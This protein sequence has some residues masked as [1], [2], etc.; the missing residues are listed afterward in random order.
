MAAEN[1]PQSETTT[2]HSLTAPDA[3]ATK[4][5]QTVEIR[6]AGPCKKHVKVTV[7]RSAID[8]RL[9]EKYSDLMFSTQSTVRGF[10]P[11]K[12]PR[13]IIERRYKK[14]VLVDIKTEVLMA[15]LEQLADEQSIS[16]LAPPELDPATIFIPEEGPFV[17]EFNIEVRPEFD[18]PPY[19]GLKLRKP[20]Y[21][22]TDADVAKQTRKMLEPMGQIVPKVGANGAE[23]TVATDDIIT[24]D[25]VIE[26]N[27]VVVNTISEVRVKVEPRLAMADGIA[28]GFAKKLSGAKVGDQR[29]VD[30]VIS[31]EVNNAS[32]RGKTFQA[33]FKVKDIKTIKQPEIDEALLS[34]FGLKAKEQLDEFVR[35]RLDQQ[36][37]NTQR[38]V[39]REGVIGHLS[40]AAKVTLPPDML[41][42]Q[43]RKS[44]NQ[45][46]IEM[47]A[48]GVSEDQIKG[49]L[50]VLEMDS[51]N[52][53]AALLQERFVLQKIAELEK[54][55][56]EDEDIENEIA[57]IADRE[58]ESYRKVRAR[59]EKEDLIESLATEL[60]ERKALDFVMASAEFEEYTLVLSDS[61]E[62]E[63]ATSSVPVLTAGQE[64]AEA[65]PETPSETP[66]S[67]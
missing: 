40:L 47:R 30:M 44:M 34:Q 43:A 22:F 54:I 57:E 67:S 58:G 38:Q 63:I 8:A 52:S 7:D 37:V 61:A 48:N 62:E 65:A 33:S 45:K 51:L 29:T 64:A 14:D 53:T 16:P 9:D 3:I 4:L 24:A 26:H 28:E 49:R 6:D 27:G 21:A 46:V 11:K 10:R 2:S 1:E 50:R 18:L 19:K 56:I 32:L 41:K 20:M 39:A 42:R 60:L 15:S 36:L 59:M 17:Y 66:A 5:P 31:Q 23:A 55:E 35:V 12:A 25:V 13:K